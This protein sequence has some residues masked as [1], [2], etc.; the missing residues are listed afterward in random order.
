M[1]IQAVANA[2]DAA[3]ITVAVNRGGARNRRDRTSH[4]LT[5]TQCRQLI[6]AA[7]RALMQERP[8]NRFIT[9]SWERGGADARDSVLLTGAF[10]R[11]AREWMAARDQPLVWAWVQEWSPRFGA[12]AHILLHVPD[13]LA[14]LFR[15]YPRRWVTK[16][17][18]GPYLAGTIKT[19]LV[20]R[21]TRPTAYA[22]TY[23][24]ALLRTVSYMLKAAPAA[25]EGP[26]GMI[27]YRSKP[28]GQHCM[29]YGK[30]MGIWQGWQDIVPGA[31]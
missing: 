25:L 30:R 13:E 3:P 12:H 28:W 31:Q 10:I 8:F 22:P 23:E 27:P 29:T 6:E 18:S 21:D 20:R 11:L 7:D 15:A 19:K 5:A 16:L 9:V 4:V 1:P 17:I 24:H 14:P 26:L 2:T